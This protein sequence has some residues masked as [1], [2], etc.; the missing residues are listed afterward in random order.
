MAD[1]SASVEE[2]ITTPATEEAK[3]PAAEGSQAL[4]TQEQVDALVGKARTKERAKY[5]NYS[6]YKAAYEE[7]QELRDSQ[8]T[9]LERATSRADA[10]QAELD[11]IKAREEQAGWR[12]EVS[13]A[14]G[15]PEAVIAGATKEEMSEHAE[16]LRQ[17]LP[18]AAKPVV[19]SDGFAPA[20]IGGRSTREQFAE[21]VKN[22][23]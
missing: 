1:A 15:I 14:T 4:L 13:K 23:F 18:D 5:P 9:D 16:A 6:E 21:A 19:A 12:R 2:A 8:R 17:L 22:A 11:A 10:L 7:L 20:S 3:S